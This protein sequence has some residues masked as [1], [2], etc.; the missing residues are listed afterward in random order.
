M[1]IRP[2]TGVQKQKQTVHDEVARARRLGPLLDPVCVQ[3]CPDFNPGNPCHRMCSWAPLR[4]SSEPQDAPLETGIVPLVFELKKLGVFE[5]CWSCEGH[6][7][8]Q[9]VL[10][11]H[12]R[13]WFY[14]DSVVHVR[15]LSIA[16]NKLFA[17]GALSAPWVVM[18]TFSDADNPDTTFSLEP[19]SLVAGA[20]LVDLKADVGVIAENLGVVFWQACN[21]VDTHVP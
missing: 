12:P 5:P 16:L 3:D 13:V 2:R 9:S 18:V 21:Q 20:K 14:S 4:L 17:N 19:S 7:D 15:A 1:K 8:A 6:N 10:W 11:K